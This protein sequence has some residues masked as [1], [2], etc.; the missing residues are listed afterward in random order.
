[1]SKAKRDLEVMLGDP[2]KAILAMLVPLSVSYFIAQINLF[3]DTF[4][5]SGLG[6]EVSSA[7]STISPIY[8]M[9]AAAGTGLGVGASS[10]IAFRLGQSD[11][12]WA[13]RL[14]GNTIVLGLI[15]SLA[16]SVLVAIFVGP[17]INLIGA[18]DIYDECMDYVMPYILMSWALIEN[19]VVA[20]LL[21]S[22][23]A[24]KKSMIV[25]IITAIINLCLD[26]LL[27]YYLDMGVFGAGIATSVSS[28]FAMMLGF[29]WYLNGS[30]NLTINRESMKPFKDAMKEVLV[31]GAPKTAESAISNLINMIQRVFFII[32]AGTVAVMLYNIPWRYVALAEVPII[33]LGAALIPIASAA[34]GQMKHEKM[35]TAVTFSVKL[36][37]VIS[38]SVAVFIFIF[39][40]PLMDVFTYS[41][42]MAVE[43]DR[44]VWVL[45]MYCLLMPANAFTLL[46]N[47]ILQALKKSLAVT[48]LMF[49]WGV[50]KLACYGI[51]CQYSFE[52][53]I[54]IMVIIFYINA[55]VMMY[56][57]RNEMK[58]RFIRDRG[59]NE[60][61]GEPMIE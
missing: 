24:A 28:M 31:V 16:A 8:W 45:R 17:V 5:T 20:G 18:S 30:M 36:T 38:V 14:A 61:P 47:S 40:D 1:M 51:A 25:L 23:G 9:I 58:K 19:G 13:S 48:I 10:T 50:L 2:K 35:Q 54:Q 42:S 27:I 49:T 52:A 26:P 21:R 53:I 44:L 41:E 6:V 59:P 46:G 60:A 11:F 7:I 39:A 22:E 33:A 56:V 15:F 37:A 4:W 3:V 55:V 32:A 34:L 29:A 57:A 12:K 43:K